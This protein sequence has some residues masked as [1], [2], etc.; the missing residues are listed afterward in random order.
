MALGTSGSGRQ[1][2]TEINVTPLVDVMLVLLIIFMVTAP[3]IQQGVEVKLPQAKAPPVKA[4]EAALVLSVRSDKSIW[5][6]EGKD[7]VQLTLPTLEEKLSANSRVAREKELYLM[8]DRGLPYGFVVEV[9]AAVQRAGVQ[10]L[11]MIT[12][13]APGEEAGGSGAAP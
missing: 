5:L 1:T 11:G 8:A 3:L 10:N 13:P 7:A 9:M 2:L 4:D 12:S 6:G